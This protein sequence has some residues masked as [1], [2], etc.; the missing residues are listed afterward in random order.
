VKQKKE[1]SKEKF[2]VFRIEKRKKE[3]SKVYFGV[4]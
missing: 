2:G 3:P 4:F 1:P